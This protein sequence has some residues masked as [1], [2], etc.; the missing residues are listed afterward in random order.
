VYSKAK[1]KHGVSDVERLHTTINQKIR[2]IET[3]DNTEN[4]PMKMEVILYTYN[5]KIK[6]NAADIF[7]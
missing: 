7:I 5:H 3:S 1:T 4:K 6:H 2:V